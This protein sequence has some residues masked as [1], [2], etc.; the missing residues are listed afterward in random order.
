MAKSKQ[1]PQ[2]SH[3]SEERIYDSS[4]SGNSQDSDVESGLTSKAKKLP[5]R[6]TNKPKSSSKLPSKQKKSVPPPS[7]TTSSGEDESSESQGDADEHEDE[8]TGSQESSS[9]SSKRRSPAREAEQPARKKSKSTATATATATTSTVQI[10]PR[11]FKAP[12]G[13][14]PVILSTSDFASQSASLFEN[15]QGKQVWHISAPDSVPL[16]VIKELDIQAALQG[17]AILTKDGID[18]NMHPTHLS[19]D[20]L[21]LPGGKHST[22]EQS[23]LRIAK[24]FHLR[25]MNSKPTHET[26]DDIETPLIFTAMEEGKARKP[27]EQPEGLK[28][29]Y[30]PFGAPPAPQNATGQDDEDVEMTTETTAFK[31]PEEIVGE[32]SSGKKSTN[33]AAETPRGEKRGKKDRDEDRG[34]DSNIKKKKKNRRLVDE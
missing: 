11:A 17:K 13:Y 30:T 21:L 12:Q 23:E 22:Y 20:V 9:E 3:L 8:E 31:V 14:E 19:N 27:R 16:D 34:T 28:M 32:R 25:Q 24:S 33:E 18:Y 4:G 26:Q 6:E 2:P 10:A 15:L 1:T 7:D 5:L 29:R